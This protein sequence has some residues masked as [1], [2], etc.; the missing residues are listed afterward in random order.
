MNNPIKK[1]AMESALI[2]HI[3]SVK[4]FKEQ[5]CKDATQGEFN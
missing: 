3:H 4:T 5:E 1:D 2:E